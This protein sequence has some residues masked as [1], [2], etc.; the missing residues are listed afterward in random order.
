MPT[1]APTDDARPER[2][3]AL[4]SVQAHDGNVTTTAERQMAV[5]HWLLATLPEQKRERARLQWDKYGVALFPLGTLFA[6]V[7]IP[8]RAVHEV[9]MTD[10]PGMVAE[11]LKAAL[12]DGPVIC[13]PARR[14][15]YVLVPPTMLRWPEAAMD[16]RGGLD[17][18]ILGTETRL[19]VPRV[20]CVGLD[21]QTRATYWTQSMTSAG[22]LCEPQA[23]ARMLNAVM[24]RRFGPGVDY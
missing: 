16:W 15:Y 11:F 13:D 22:M 5:R 2:I 3:R 10:N 19:G 17:V 1:S 6:A 7:R 21:Q 18:E 20:D 9:A 23:V 8:E 24:R 12:D 14:L 4:R